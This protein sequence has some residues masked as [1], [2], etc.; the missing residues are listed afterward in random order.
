[1]SDLEAVVVLSDMLLT[2]KLSHDQQ[3]ALQVAIGALA[4]AHLSEIGEVD[5]R[6]AAP[7]ARTN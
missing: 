1:M 5:E 3:I 4:Q 2:G 7:V 6:A